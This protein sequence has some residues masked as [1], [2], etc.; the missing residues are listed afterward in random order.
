MSP[1]TTVPTAI[2]DLS[3]VRKTEDGKVSVIDVISQ[4]KKCQA[5]YAAQICKRLEGQFGGLEELI[6]YQ[7]IKTSDKKKGQNRSAY[8]SPVI[9][10]RHVQRIVD[11]LPGMD[12]RALRASDSRT[13][14][15]GPDRSDDLYIM[16]YSNDQTALKIGRAR[17]VE[18]RRRQLESGHNFHMRVLATFPKRGHLEALVHSALKGVR[19]CEGAGKEWFEVSIEEAI[20][21]INR[22]MAQNRPLQRS[23]LLG[24]KRRR[25]PFP[26]SSTSSSRSEELSQSPH[27]KKPS[28]VSYDDSTN[29]SHGSLKSEKN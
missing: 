4:I 15:S 13:T 9:E 12:A 3:K 2:M 26:A 28:N 6:T 19:C 14:F 18:H 24:T 27:H 8:I 7:H 11:L 22:I 21:T 29:S 23:E 1:T 10:Q 17:N 20:D 16:Q 5:H 25:D